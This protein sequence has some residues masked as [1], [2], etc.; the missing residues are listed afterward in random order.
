MKRIITRGKGRESR[1]LRQTYVII[2]YMINI[3]KGILK[4]CHSRY[5]HNKKVQITGK[6]KTVKEITSSDKAEAGLF[7]KPT[8]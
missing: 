8:K 5:N 1:G 6:H 4:K 2:L 3:R 7:K